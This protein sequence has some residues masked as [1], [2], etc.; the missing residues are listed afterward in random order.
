M[1][2]QNMPEFENAETCWADEYV[3]TGAYGEPA[4]LVRECMENVLERGEPDFIDLRKESIAALAQ[5]LQSFFNETLVGMVE[6]DDDS[7]NPLFI[8]A[9]N[10]ALALVN[11][12][13]IAAKYVNAAR[14][15]SVG[16]NM[17]GYMPDSS[18]AI[19]L[20]RF[21]AVEQLVA[22][23][24]EASEELDGQNVEQILA[25]IKADTSGGALSV[26]LGNYRY[27]LELV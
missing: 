9:I 14:V 24:S 21:A 25:E 2:T 10:S 8:N 1:D 5:D 22:I 27:W 6:A 19:F 13:T 17:P 23:V 12:Q 15:Y 18:P 7:A 26:G 3:Q 16:A 11:W 20:D 4:Q